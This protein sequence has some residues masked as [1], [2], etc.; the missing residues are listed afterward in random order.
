MAKLKLSS[1]S[2]ILREWYQNH[3]CRSPSTKIVKSC[4]LFDQEGAALHLTA[5]LFLTLRLP[6]SPS[7]APPY[8]C[9]Q[10]AAVS[11]LLDVGSLY[12]GLLC[13]LPPGPLDCLS[14][15]IRWQAQVAALLFPVV[16]L[17]HPEG[18]TSR[19]WNWR[20]KSFSLYLLLL[21]VMAQTDD[22]S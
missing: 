18:S 12:K 7:V 19:Q 21:K 17:R 20:R 5:K 22:I 14:H 11:E 16:T 6:S 3:N 8:H 15:W 13:S 1:Q 4:H 9:R 2:L 10:V